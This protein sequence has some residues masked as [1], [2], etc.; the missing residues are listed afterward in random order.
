M[1]G[2]FYV[3]ELI[4][5]RDGKPFYVGKGVRNRVHQH[6]RDA[7]RGA[8][9]PRFDRIRDIAAAGL[10]VAHRIVQR[11]N[12]SGA[13]YGFEADHIAKLGMVNLTNLSPGGGGGYAC[14]YTAEEDKWLARNLSR[15]SARTANFTWFPAFVQLGRDLY[16]MGACHVLSLTLMHAKLIRRRG[17][18]WVAKHSAFSQARSEA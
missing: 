17:A 8:E 5:P 6:A 7:A 3:Y 10:V 15:L 12:D 13:A 16:P 2:K 18:E 14:E 9:G 4:D 1:S 11:F